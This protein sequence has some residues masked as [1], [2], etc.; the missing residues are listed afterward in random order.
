[1]G[2]AET[3]M[4]QQG[5]T[6]KSSITSLV[7]ALTTSTALSL[8]SAN[9]QPVTSAP[10]T[11][12]SPTA[13]SSVVASLAEVIPDVAER[14][15]KSVVSIKAT[16]QMRQIE[17][18]GWGGSFDS[19]MP[20]QRAQ[21]AGSGVIVNAT[22]RVV[23]NAHVVRSASNISVELS[24]GTEFPAVVIGVDDRTDIA[25]LQ[26][27]GTVPK[28]TPLAIGSSDALRLGEVVLAIGNPFGVGHSVSMGI[29]SAKSRRI[30]IETDEDFLQTDAAI[31]PGNS[32]GALVNLRGELV[33]INTAI[34]SRTNAGVGFAIPTSM[35]TPIVDMIVKDGKV[36]R[37]Y[38]G[39]SMQ[40]LTP[41]LAKQGGLDVTRGIVLMGVEPG[42]PA[43]GSELKPGDIIIAVNGQPVKDDFAFKT[44]VGLSKVGSTVSLDVVKGGKGAAKNIAVKLGLFPESSKSGPLPVPKKSRVPAPILRPDMP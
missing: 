43:A 3:Q 23:T 42:S 7:I 6:M 40:S 28:L 33:G 34:A 14:T 4:A 8:V 27:K 11:A 37:A 16:Q 39:I 25:V 13:K 18:D 44:M 29:I 22:G 21:S 15:V 12:V 19:G 30:G 26:L 2:E 38:L 1:V 10:T 31:N 41:E 17:W 9:A 24:D 36:S 32:G 20:E 35:M 5:T